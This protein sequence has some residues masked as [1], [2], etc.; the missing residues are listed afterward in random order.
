MAERPLVTG[1]LDVPAEHHQGEHVSADRPPHSGPLTAPKVVFFD[2]N[3]TL[4]DLS[5]M[6]TYF[7]RVGAPSHLAGMWFA[8]LLRDGFALA[9]TGRMVAFADIAAAGLRTLFAGVALDRSVED[10][11]SEVMSGFHELDVHADVPAGIPLLAE[12]ELRLVTLSNGSASVAEALLGR[13]GVRQH[14][15]RLLS[16]EA[17]GV[18][19][20]S[21]QAYSYGLVSCAVDPAEALLVAVHP[22]DID[23]AARAGLSTAWLN[24]AGLPYPG[25][26]TSPTME[27]GSLPELAVQLR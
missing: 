15:D 11:V 16:V 27:L 12:L 22:W 18:W 21:A 24:R 2:V 17:A 9:A 23:G 10:A 7:E 8:A 3:E 20:P 25:Y 4:S 5:S 14:F 19:K 13:A 6:G 26:F 1:A